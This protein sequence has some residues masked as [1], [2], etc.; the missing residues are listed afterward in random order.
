MVAT[1]HYLIHGFRWLLHD[2]SWFMDLNGCY[3]SWFMDLNGCYISWFMATHCYIISYHI[4]MDS[5]LIRCYKKLRWGGLDKHYIPPRL[6]SWHRPR[7]RRRG[8][9]CPSRSH[10][11]TRPSNRRGSGRR[12]DPRIL[13]GLG[14]TICQRSAH[15]AI[16]ANTTQRGIYLMISTFWTYTQSTDTERK[17]KKERY[18]NV[19]YSQNWPMRQFGVQ[20]NR[21]Y[22]WC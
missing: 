7:D 1:W 20:Q 8:Q 18:S 14:H 6:C 13:G 16:K 15:H 10:R 12:R 21:T 11:G 19:F 2:I 22:K 5:I 9:P 4:L 3:I 17:K